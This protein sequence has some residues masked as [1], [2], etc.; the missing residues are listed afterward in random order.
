MVREVVAGQGVEQVRVV[1]Q[2]G[3]GERNKLPVP[4]RRCAVRGPGQVRLRLGGADTSAAATSKRGESRWS[5]ADRGSRLAPCR[6]RRS[7]G[8]SRT[9]ISMGMRLTVFVGADDPLTAT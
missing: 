3:G 9:S 2:V 7:A 4:G 5:R 1:V 8:R 6:R